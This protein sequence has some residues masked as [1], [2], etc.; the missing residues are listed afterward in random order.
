LDTYRFASYG[1]DD[2]YY[3]FS[4]VALLILIIAC[5]NFINLSTARASLRLKEVSIRK[6]IGAFRKQLIY[7]FLGESMFLSFIALFIAAI[8]IKI[9]LPEFNNLLQKQIS[10]DYFNLNTI[11]ILSLVATITGLLAGAYP[12]ILISSYTPVQILRSRLTISV[13]KFN[14][15][16]ILVVTQYALSA[17]FLICATI[18]S[19]QIWFMN[20][21]DK[22]L[23]KK[24]LYYVELQGEA[25]SKINLI[26]NELKKNPKIQSVTSSSHLPSLITFGAFQKWG[27]EDLPDRWIVEANVD[28][29]FLETT[30]LKMKEGRFFSKAFISDSSNAVI[31]NERAAADLGPDFGIG[32]PFLFEG[33]YYQVIGIMSDFHHRSMDQLIAPIIFTLKENDNR[34][35]V[36]KV[37]SNVEKE[38]ERLSTLD[39]IKNT[40]NSFSPKNPLE[41]NH[42]ESLELQVDRVNHR[43]QMLL[44]SATIFALIISSLGLFALSLYMSQRKRKEISIRK[45]LGSSIG[46]AV[47]VLSREF[48]ILLSIAFVIAIPLAYYFMSS[49]LESFPYRIE[50]QF[51]MF[52]VNIIFIFLTAFITIIFQT[53][54]AANSNP[55]DVL[56]YE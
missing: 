36:L 48:I 28:Y 35:I 41:V 25:Q 42:L 52:A 47:Y 16:R 54:K 10:V 20:N 37:S 56:K 50:I 17:L 5:I 43:T 30:E 26:R 7:Q 3:I 9:L 19:S 44:I 12:A 14:L 32:D 45:V 40:V 53:I 4:F 18:V 11:L 55:T 49:F 29:D 24:D 33:E 34:F 23:N 22:Q 38:G 46:N 6:V 39:F 8:I 1:G 15:R 2:I 51:W 21:K 27:K 13:G 31:I